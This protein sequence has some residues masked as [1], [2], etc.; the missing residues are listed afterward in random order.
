M[1]ELVTQI[2]TSICITRF[3]NSIFENSEPLYMVGTNTN[4]KFLITKF[5]IKSS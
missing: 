1:L 2:V 4:E 3:R 5:I